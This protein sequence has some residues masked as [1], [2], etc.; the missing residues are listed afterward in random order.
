MFPNGNHTQKSSPECSCIS[1]GFINYLKSLQ[2]CTCLLVY[3]CVVTNKCALPVRA[4]AGFNILEDV[5]RGGYKPPNMHL[6]WVQGTLLNS[7]GDSTLYMW[8]ICPAL[9]MHTFVKT[10]L[11]FISGIYHVGE[12]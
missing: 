11:L 7:S 1:L 8:A 3:V 10:M 6:M 9:H 2:L 12:F 4:E 5:V